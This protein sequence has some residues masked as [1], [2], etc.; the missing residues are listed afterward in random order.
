MPSF[1]SIAAVALALPAA[2]I[3]T[4]ARAQTAPD[5][6]ERVLLRLPGPDWKIG[7][8]SSV[9]GVSLTEMVMSNETIDNWTSLVTI[10]I[11]F[12]ARITPERMINALRA[13]LNKTDI[14]IDHATFAGELVQQDGMDAAAGTMICGRTKRT[15]DG[16]VTLFVLLRGE[17]NLCALFRA[18]RVPPFVEGEGGIDEAEIRAGFD[19]LR[20]ATVCNPRNPQRPCPGPAPRAL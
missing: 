1:R 4:A 18:W 14:C 8:T 13:N 11:F 17:D 3:A 2:W 10:S 12:D 20:R 15:G 5:Q 6:R 19:V 7:S 9:P 16:E